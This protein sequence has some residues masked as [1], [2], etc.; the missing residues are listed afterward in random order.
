MA[1]L[2]ANA[3]LRNI[4]ESATYATFDQRC[5]PYYGFTPWITVGTGYRR[6][7]DQPGSGWFAWVSYKQEGKKAEFY[8]EVFA[9]E[10]EAAERFRSQCFAALGENREVRNVEFK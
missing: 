6:E 7:N 2:T 10:A 9:T 5:G 3:T 1:T 8:D 4:P